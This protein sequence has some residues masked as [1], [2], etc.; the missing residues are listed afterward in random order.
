MTPTDLNTAV[1]FDEPGFRLSYAFATNDRGQ[2]VGQ[3]GGLG[4]FL[5]TPCEGASCVP[6]VEVLHAVPAPVIGAG[7]LAF[8]LGGVASDALKWSPEFAS[9][10][11]FRA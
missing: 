10:F 3:G 7:L 9:A 2:I 4:G 5:L 1:P 8:L 6:P 11:I